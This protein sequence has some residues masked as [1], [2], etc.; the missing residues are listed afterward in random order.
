MNRKYRV[1]AFYVET[2]RNRTVNLIVRHQDDVT[3]I[4]KNSGFL[5]PFEI[6]EVM[7]EPPTQQQFEQARI[8]SITLPDG[9]SK[10]DANAIISKKV[11]GDSEPQ[12]GLIEYAY[13]KGLL[14]S[15]YVGKKELYDLIYDGLATVDRIAFFIFEVYRWVSEDRDSNLNKH[16]HKTLFYEFAKQQLGNEKFLKALNRY[17]GQDVRFFG[18]LK[19][20]DGGQARGG[21]TDTIPYQTSAE[22]LNIKLGIQN[23]E[24]KMMDSVTRKIVDISTPQKIYTRATTNDITFFLPIDIPNR[25]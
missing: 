4:L 7:L 6:K 5:E 13:E 9:A 16:K 17:S 14:L 23:V 10:E 12:L 11:F 19:F 1:K 2:K 18:T 21:R 8:L 22:F 25:T 15:K 20:T 24:I 3:E